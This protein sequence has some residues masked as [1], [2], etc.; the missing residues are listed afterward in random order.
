[1]KEEMGKQVMSIVIR[2]LWETISQPFL[3]GGDLQRRITLIA[4]AIFLQGVIEFPREIAAFLL[5]PLTDIAMI[6]ALAASLA[7]II[8]AIVSP[9]QQINTIKQRRLTYFVFVLCLGVSLIFGTRQIVTAV[10]SSFS[11][12][13]YPN[14]GTTLDQH[15]AMVLLEGQNPYTST[16]IVLAAKVLHQAGEFT[17]PLRRGTFLNRSWLDYPSRA[18]MNALMIKAQSDPTHPAPEFESRVSYPA[19]SFLMLLPFV[20]LGMPSVVLSTVILYILFAIFALRAVSP[21]VRPWVGLLFVADIPL[22][23]G[24]AIGQLDIALFIFVFF[25]WLWRDRPILSTIALG[26]AISTK[27]QAWFF[28]IFLV[29]YLL[30]YVGWRQTLLRL[31]GAIGLFTI[32]NVPFILQNARAWFEGIMAPI[33]DP[34]FPLGSGLV[35]LSLSRPDRFVLLPLLPQ[36]VYTVLE[37]LALLVAIIWYYRVGASLYPAMGIILSMLPLWFAW[38]S[39]SS[40]FYFCALPMLILWLA[41]QQTTALVT[42]Q[43]ARNSS[44]FSKAEESLYAGI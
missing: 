4:G 8:I 25:A 2:R 1:V 30:Q 24:V 43:A 3:V 14:D 13:L 10:Q 29:I 6:V 40:Y 5:G 18:E 33:S 7:M 12:P 26:L 35:G 16:N 19:F 21:Q 15:A 11:N 36:T 32:I 34:M 27:Q 41:W 44:T 31:S 42:S 28:T 39:L 20:A 9:P 17:T 22:V 37:L 38:R 23:E